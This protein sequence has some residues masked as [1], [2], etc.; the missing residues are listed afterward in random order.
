M[1][2]KQGLLIRCGRAIGGVKPFA[3]VSSSVRST[4]ESREGEEADLAVHS[5]VSRGALARSLLSTGQTVA[6]GVRGR[7]QQGAWWFM[8]RVLDMLESLGSG[9][10]GAGWGGARCLVGRDGPCSCT[11]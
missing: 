10:D 5:P 4:I 7:P 2:S 1:G 9:T 6:R 11:F 3:V 8:R